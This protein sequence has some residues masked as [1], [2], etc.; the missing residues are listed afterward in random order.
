M[1]FR[2]CISE[3]VEAGEI[4][5]AEAARLNGEFDRLR[6]KFAA[7]SEVTADA[8]AKRA[9]ADLLKAETD[10]QRR[11][12]KLSVA[13]IR[14]V[15]ADI[16]SYRNPKGEADINAA[17]LDL[18]EHYG[19]AK[20][21]SVEGR[22]KSII[23]MAHARMESLLYDF[24]KGA[25][26]GDPGRWNKARLENVVRE[27]FGQDTGDVAAKGL[28]KT[29]DTTSDWLRRRF[30][31]AGGAIGKLENWGL[32][33]HHDARAMLKRGREQWKADIAP[34][35]ATDRMRHPLSGQPVDAADLDSILDDIYDSITTD[36]WSKREPSRMA[37]GKGA[38]ANQRGDH[39]FLV[40]KDPDNWFEYQRDYGGGGDA[41]AAMMGHINMMSRDIA[42][43]EILGPNPSATVEWLKQAVAKNAAGKGQKAADAAASTD[44]RLDTIWGSIRGTLETPVNSRWG[45]YAAAARNLITASVLGGATLSSVS[46]IGTSILARRF[47]GLTARGVLPELVK[48]MTPATRREAVAAGLILDNAMHVFH[49]QA[50]YV[51]TLDGPG[52]SS[53]I[54]DRVLTYSGLTP[55]TQAGR[56]AFGL[57]F[58]RTAAEQAKTAFDDLPAPLRR[59]FE[60]HGIRAGDWDKMRRMPLHDIGKSTKIMRPNEIAERIDERLG[61]R[62][63]AMILDETEYAIPSGSHRS[64]TAILD[65][66]RP[67][68]LMGEI[69]RSMAQFKSFAAV[70]VFLHGRRIHQEIAGGSKMRGAAYAG[71]L[72]ISTTI[73][74]ALA[75][76]LKQISAGRDPRDMSDWKEFIPASVLQGG[77]LG[78]FG[79]FMF[80]NVNRYGSGLGSTLAGP[81]I[82]RVDN[83]RNLT[84]GNLA[85]LAAG[86]ETKFGKEL[87][88]F[89]KG[90]TP[91]SNIWYIRLA[92]E[93][94]L[95]DQLQYLADP[96]ANKAFKRQQ[97]FWKKEFGQDY[98]WRPGQMTPDRAPDLGAV[99]PG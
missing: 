9:L 56:H 82:E 86:Q 3:A 74:G 88:R 80:A 71:S 84:I 37:T 44:R 8:E 46:D 32:P 42:A 79:D 95:L 45:G 83:L 23:G 33:Q 28:A 35:L 73:F 17:A 59:T 36:G 89:A 78:I 6:A 58:M 25:V 72:L 87:L 29:W 18:L 57:A 75:L 77:G 13:S 20:F 69:V 60:R 27:A 51:G 91:G 49:A 70:M 92:W 34:R 52:W 68:T 54:A 22:R 94:M 65:Q 26:R 61:E 40:F 43:M 16:N 55:W 12:A 93:R 96:E 62:Y 47:T 98:F 85:E 63:L 66:N 2:D 39:R 4:G 81:M 24:R 38:L 5:K 21:D 11:K 76:Q 30:N 14:R 64:R 10:H 90:N 97:Q 53:Y 48:A 7:G 99:A 31:A 50:R 1:S 41:F 67:G 19:T 15:A